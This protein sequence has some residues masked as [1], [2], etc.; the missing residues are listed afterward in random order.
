MIF[1]CKNITFRLLL[2]LN[3]FKYLYRTKAIFRSIYV[4]PYFGNSNQFMKPKCLI[5]FLLFHKI[6][7]N[8][9]YDL[10]FIINQI[11]YHI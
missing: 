10:I 4:I 6:Y 11:S 2:L 7:D 3:Y 5:I 8:F 9:T 1:F